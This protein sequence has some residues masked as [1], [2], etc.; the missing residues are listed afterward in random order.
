MPSA[1]HEGSSATSLAR[2]LGIREGSRVLVLGAPDGFSLGRLPERVRMARSARGQIDVVLFFVRQQNPLRRRFPTLLRSLDPAGRLWVAWPKK[3]AR[4]DTGLT[5]DLVQRV[6]LD[7]GLVDNKSAS[8]D[9]VYQ[10]LQFVY[11]L[12]DRPPNARR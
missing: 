5:F 9:D 1:G 8:I 6:G 12:K 10:G 4:V 11:R 3:A 7:A 2:K